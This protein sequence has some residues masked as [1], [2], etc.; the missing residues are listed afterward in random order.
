MILVYV[1]FESKTKVLY[2]SGAN[3]CIISKKNNLFLD[4]DI[5][6]VDRQ[7]VGSI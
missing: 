5:I 2:S 1:K 4:F 3:N 6:K 7:P